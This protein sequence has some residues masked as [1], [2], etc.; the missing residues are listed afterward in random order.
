MLCMYDA[1]KAK[2]GSK[3]EIAMIGITLFVYLNSYFF[4]IRNLIIMKY[5]KYD[6]MN[7]IP[8]PRIP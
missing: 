3:I 6:K 1:N 7:E 4:P 8:N 5:V 2:D